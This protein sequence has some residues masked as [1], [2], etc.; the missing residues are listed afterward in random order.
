MTGCASTKTPKY[1]ED[2]ARFERIVEV[3]DS[4][5]QAYVEKNDSA[6]RELFLPL[7]NLKQ[8]DVEIQ[9]DFQTYSQITLDLSIER[10]TIRDDQI[11]VNIRWQG[12]WTEESNAP[13]TQANGHG[14]LHWRGRQVILL[15]GV[16]GDIPFGMASHQSIS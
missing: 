13:V 16:E 7:D 10:I 3:I 9:R 14:I 4:L 11:L 15:A 8:L 2:H 12:E 6:A 5:R 1:P